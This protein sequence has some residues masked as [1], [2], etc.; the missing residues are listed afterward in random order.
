MAYETELRRERVLLAGC[1]LP[2]Q[3]LERFD[4][5]MGEL[6]ALTQTAHGETVGVVTQNRERIHPAFYAG[7]G[8]IEEM[9]E[10]VEE[11]EVETVIFNGELSAGQAGNI[12][13]MLGVKVID[14]TQL[15]L[16]IFA[17]RARSKEGK[18]QVEL[19]QLK[20][21]LPRL[22]GKGTSLSRLGGGIGTRGPGETKLEQDRRHIRRRITDIEKQ[23]DTI[24]HHRERY[25]ERRRR[26]QSFQISLVGYTNAGKS[27]LFNKLTDAG[28]FEEN[29]LFATL[30]PLT[31]KF[32]L[33]SGLE[34]L[35]SDTVGFIQDLP[36]TLIAA[37]RSTL[38]EIKEANLILHVI[39]AENPDFEQHEETVLRLLK[40]LGADTIPILTVYN[41]IDLLEE[42]FIASQ[43]TRSVS[44]SALKEKDIDLLKQEIENVM[45]EEM[46]YY[47]ASIPLAEGKLLSK[48]GTESFIDQQKIDEESGTVQI[49]GYISADLPLYAELKPYF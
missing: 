42:A 47:Q 28:T 15:I 36:T 11:L 22:S 24:V 27:T 9:A 26:N 38:E 40:E 48:L 14:R 46:T 20:Y 17:D 18:L 37:F 12:A 49:K 44:I 30:D 2:K 4:H 29:L 7:R 23:L 33:P 32:Q 39:D 8:K 19:A 25:R 1:H 5:S 43:G 3:S 13:S 6:K 34:V 10:I 41:K 35:A 45:K 31:R 21:L 16:D